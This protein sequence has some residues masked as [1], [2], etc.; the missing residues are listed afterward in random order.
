[1]SAHA[2][3]VGHGDQGL[4][5]TSRAVVLADSD[6]VSC[7]EPAEF[8]DA[9]ERKAGEVAGG[10][11]ILTVHVVQTDNHSDMRA[12]L[13]FLP[14]VVSLA[15]DVPGLSTEQWIVG[16][17][18]QVWRDD[19]LDLLLSADRGRPPYSLVVVSRSN[20]AKAL[21]PAE[22]ELAMASDLIHALTTTSLRSTIRAHGHATAQ[23]GGGATAVYY[24]REPLVAA[25]VAHNV[26]PFMRD[27]L[28]A[29][30]SPSHVI[31]DRAN[32]WLSEHLGSDLFE[33]LWVG[34]NGQALQAV[35]AVD[36]NTGLG[37][38]P[39]VLSDS[40]Q[41]YAELMVQDRLNRAMLRVDELADLRREALK[42]ALFSSVM[43][44]LREHQNLGKVTEFLDAIHNQL[45]VRIGQVRARIHEVA[46]LTTSLLEPVEEAARRV[47]YP[48]TGLVRGVGLG[49]GGMGLGLALMQLMAAGPA[50]VAG[51]GVALVGAGSAALQT[52]ARHAAVNAA[53]TAFLDA[54]QQH[55]WEKLHHYILVRHIE[56][57]GYLCRLIRRSDDP[58][59]GLQSGVGKLRAS[60]EALSRH[61]E[62][63]AKTRNHEQYTT[64]EFSVFLPRP[65]DSSTEELAREHP[66]PEGFDL[67]D[68]V[69]ATICEG[70]SE[71]SA[72]EP[73]EILGR[74]LLR[75]R[76]N[77]PQ[78]LWDDLGDLF[79][80][81]P[82]AVDV[83]ATLLGVSSAPLVKVAEDLPQEEVRQFIYL[84]E[85]AGGVKQELLTRAQVKA[86]QASYDSNAAS[87]VS[88]RSVIEAKGVGDAPR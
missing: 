26:L 79:Q 88:L 30:S 43:A 21:L 58:G 31:T 73:G 35:L 85:S 48:G 59:A 15:Q 56:I 75:M 84:P 62:A 83:A 60:C 70:M 76:D 41:S 52:I 39:E 17:V 68:A 42:Q 61:L 9:L 38:A 2:I 82:A 34:V 37:V 5:V 50:L 32:G 36:F 24:R 4:T 7:C 12:A 23:V 33:Q 6:R 1:M 65:E 29:P 25:I 77:Q 86:S 11:T 55:V 22:A 72:F 27:E 51:A 64:T 47:P 66:L 44:A 3:L 16:V 49:V 10:T 8:L 45:D 87:A 13:N 63:V 54:V 46:D 74:L 57:F 69:V 40:L 53:R 78:G 18:G 20:Q 67:P 80:R 81:S 71:P 19:E 14:Q 28:L